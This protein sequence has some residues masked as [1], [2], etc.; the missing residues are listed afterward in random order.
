MKGPE[1]LNTGKGKGGKGKECGALGAHHHIGKSINNK[2]VH[3]LT[4]I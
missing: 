1:G 4:K 2:N 3:S